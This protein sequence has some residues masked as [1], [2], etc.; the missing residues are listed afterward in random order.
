[1]S[2]NQVWAVIPSRRTLLTI[3]L[4]SLLGGILAIGI[5]NWLRSQDGPRPSPGPPHDPHFIHIGRT[6]LPELG[7][8]YASAWD[9][10]AKGLEAGQNLSSGVSAVAKAWDTN[11]TQLFDR[12]ATPEFLKLIPEAKKDADVTPQERAAMAAAWRG[13]AIGLGE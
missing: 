7:K 13:F 3:T 4:S 2:I 9:E 12:I 10:G 11:R 8:A 6:Y 5:S 1:M